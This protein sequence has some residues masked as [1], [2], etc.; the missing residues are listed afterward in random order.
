MDTYAIAT[1][2]VKFEENYLI[3]KRASTKRF[4]PNK[5][6]FLSGFVE[7]KESAENTVLRELEEETKLNGKIIKTAESFTFIDD[8]ARWVVIPFLIEVKNKK[9]I[10]N[11]N[12][13]SEAKW[14]NIE[15]LNNFPDLLP[16]SK[17][18]H[19]LL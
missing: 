14:I 15:E 11:N 16:F 7:E 10:I 4:A 5:W 19:L 2:L 12:D 8:E 3:L 17:L 18:I 13:H 6:E 9:I 1:A